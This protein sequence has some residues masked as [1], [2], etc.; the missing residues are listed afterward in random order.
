[1]P[2]I[3]ERLTCYIA[4]LCESIAYVLV[5]RGD[6]AR[7]L[8]RNARDELACVVCISTA[9][10]EEE[11]GSEALLVIKFAGHGASNRRLSRTGQAMQP[12]NAVSAIGP[13]IYLLEEV[14]ARIVKAFWVVSLVCVESRA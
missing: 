13:V 2:L 6:I 7:Q 10:R 4:A 12:E 11:A 8:P 14:D 9:A 1:M 3:A 5:E